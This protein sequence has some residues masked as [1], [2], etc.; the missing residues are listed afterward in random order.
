MDDFADGDGVTLSTP[1]GH[2][3]SASVV[4]EGIGANARPPVRVLVAAPLPR[5]SATQRATLIAPPRA[6]TITHVGQEPAIEGSARKGRIGTTA[7]ASA[8][9][10]AP[11]KHS[12]R[13]V[14]DVPPERATDT[15]PAAQEPATG[16]TPETA[17]SRSPAPAT[18]CAELIDLQR[19]RRFCIRM[20]SRIDRGLDAGLARQLGYHT[21]LPEAEGKALFR[22]VAVL[23]KA[24][25][26]EDQLAV[27]SERERAVA[28]VWL[29]LI[30]QTEASRLGWDGQRNAIET[31]MRELARQ[32]P[33]W[34]WAASIRGFAPLGLAI[35]VGEACG[36]DAAELGDYHSHQNLCKRLGIGVVDGHRQGSPGKGATPEDW[37][38][39]GY[40]PARRAEIW[41]ILDYSLR[42]AQWRNDKVDD[43][44]VVLREG[45]PQGVYGAIYVRQVAEYQARGW[46][47]AKKAAARFMAKALIRDLWRA[48]R[49]Y[50]DFA[51]GERAERWA[52]KGHTGRAPAL[53][54]AENFAEGEEV[55][56][57]SPKGQSDIAPSLG[58]A[59]E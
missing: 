11:A 51:E 13:R 40:A 23:R 6:K 1:Q 34:E 33:V 30:L 42:N 21:K 46:P 48:W 52:P 27:L 58:E 50:G 29:P 55:A 18:I 8:I 12:K 7:A 37:V 59:A 20:Q 31:A 57:S 54:E 26:T 44:G 41:T 28:K 5:P 25:V 22:R 3:E 14:I 47:H 56:A 38:R 16:G 17:T 39:E 45:G 19:Q 2:R 43:A 4:S 10:P 35:I 9:A 53:G 32:L 24:V 15:A 49:R 36:P